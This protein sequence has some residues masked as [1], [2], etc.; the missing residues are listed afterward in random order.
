MSVLLLC[1]MLIFLSACGDGN[2]KFRSNIIS[3]N[4]T[5]VDGY[6]QGASICL[7]FNNDGICSVTEAKTTTSNEGTFSFEDINTSQN[8]FVTLLSSGG[9]DTA[10]DNTFNDD[11][12][13]IINVYKVPNQ[14]ITTPFT[15]LVAISFLL[16]SSPQDAMALTT[17][18][19][20]ISHAF[21]LDTTELNQDPMQNIKLF[22]HVQ[23]LQHIKA[24]LTTIVTSNSAEYTYAD[25]LKKV[26]KVIVEQISYASDL[27]DFINKILTILGF[28]YT[29]T[30]SE[31]AK[32]F[33][34]DNILEYKI[35]L[36]TLSADPRVTVEVLDRLQKLLEIQRNQIQNIIIA[37]DYNATID[38]LDLEMLINSLV[39]SDFNTTDAVWD[40]NA[41]KES[42]IYKKIEHTSWSAPGVF[43]TDSA[44]GISIQ[45]KVSANEHDL[46][47]STLVELYY[48]T[49]DQNRTYSQTVVFSSSYNFAF[50][51][52]WTTNTNKYIYIKTPKDNNNKSNCYRYRLS[53]TIAE[54]I[55]P[56]KVYRY[57]DFNA[58]DI[59]TTN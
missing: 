11:L 48:P 31:E 59:N 15:D 58:T 2:S 23:F 7:D 42:D 19:E 22:L 6:I 24:L 8:L 55:L 36:N 51:Q 9:I 21:E 57:T 43:T 38:P 53:S 32:D 27:R 14:L 44:N 29:I 41:C 26:K 54:N 5:L 28:E 35:F 47:N 52:A 39:Q 13:N 45:S 49:L 20:D 10:T 50:D 16:E 17:S 1:I 30:I 37:S 4:G 40:E 33:I 46:L 56:V 12:K 25:V 3:L 18:K 34:I